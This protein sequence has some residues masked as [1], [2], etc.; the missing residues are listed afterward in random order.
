CETPPGYE[1]AESQCCAAAVTEGDGYCST[2][3]WDS[4]CHEAYL[5]CAE[6]ELCNDPQACNYSSLGSCGTGISCVYAAWFIPFSLDTSAPIYACEAPTGYV[7]TCEPCFTQVAPP[8]SDCTIIWGESCQ[9]EYNACLDESQLGCVEP[10]ACNYN[11]IAC[12]ND[13][14]CIEPQWYYPEN[15]DAGSFAVFACEQPAGYVLADQCCA[16]S[17]QNGEGIALDALQ[18]ISGGLEDLYEECINGCNDP[19]ACDYYPHENCY[20]TGNCSFAGYHLPIT[21]NSPPFYGC[22]SPEGYYQVES[23]CCFA[24]VAA[25]DFC[26]GEAWGPECQAAYLECLNGC[27]DEAACNYSPYVQDESCSNYC[28][29]PEMYV[30]IYDTEGG[31]EM[32]CNPVEGYALANV[33]CVDYAM[34]SEDHFCGFDDWDETCKEIYFACTNTYGCTDEH[35]CN[36][37]ELST[38][39]DGSCYGYSACSNEDAVNFDPEATCNSG[40]CVFPSSCPGDFNNDDQVNASDLLFFLGNFGTLCGP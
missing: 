39:D 1:L 35:A 17:I 2:V 40:D 23:T 13:G 21:G 32:F 34:E 29:F 30:P 16:V 11:P 12:G 10:N 22:E 19:T 36:F 20:D 14:S 6:D 7:Q 33:N 5:A 15:L 26:N 25:E 31:P 38:T 27:H 37:N 4:I 3:N 9:L 24:N 28:D 8:N 18:W